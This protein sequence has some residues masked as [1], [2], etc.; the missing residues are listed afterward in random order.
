MKIALEVDGLCAQERE[1]NSNPL[2]ISATWR[3]NLKCSE[4][5]LY[6]KHFEL[7]VFSINTQ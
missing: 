5:V 2:Y 3:I 6:S 1:S 4:L 7:L